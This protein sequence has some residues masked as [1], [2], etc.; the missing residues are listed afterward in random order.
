M[1]KLR[2]E[3]EELR[4]EAFETGRGGARGTVE[5]HSDTAVVAFSCRDEPID[6]R[7]TGPG[8]W[9]CD[10]RCLAES[11]SYCESCWHTCGHPAVC[12]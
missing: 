6:H 3:L 7:E 1:R 9:S 2:L 4:V 12:G 5:G 8:D 11:F 10:D